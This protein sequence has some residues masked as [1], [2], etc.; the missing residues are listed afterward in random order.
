MP[1][2]VVAAVL[3]LLEALGWLGVGV[4]V[5]VGSDSGRML[6]DVTAT[7]FFVALGAGLLLCAR[8]L[9]RVRRW[10]R[11]P[12]VLA[13]L[14]QVLVAWSFLSGET[15]LVAVLLAGVAVVVLV[16]VL[17]PAATRALVRDE[18]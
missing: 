15:T 12:V 6:L 14:I 7:V 17:S 16:A 4:S 18:G 3:V 2:L 10:A 5:V 9:L 8:G 13:Q 11:A 1:A